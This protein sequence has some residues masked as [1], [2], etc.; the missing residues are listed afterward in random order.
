MFILPGLG[1]DSTATPS[2][3]PTPAPVRPSLSESRL[4]EL[5]LFTLQL[6][7]KDRID[8]GLSPVALGSNPAAQSH[9]E[10]MLVH[11]YLGHWWVDGRKPYMVYSETRGQSYV[12]ENAASSGWTQEGWENANCDS[13][14]VSCI[15]TQPADALKE[16]EHL[17]MYDDAHADWGHRDNILGN[18]HRFVNIGIAWDGRRT[19]LAQHFEG[20]DV[21]ANGRPALSTDGTLSFRLTKVAEDIEVGDLVTVYYDPPPSPKTPAQIDTLDSYCIGGGFTTACDHKPVAR[22]LE[23]PGPGFYY[24][25]LDPNEIV[26]DSWSQSSTSFEVTA[27]LGSRATRPGVYTVMVWQ[28]SGSPL[29]SDFWVA[30]SVVQP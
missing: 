23:P 30:L 5:R 13:V 3:T 27:S 24:P 25:N 9:A 7:N 17:M 4:A 15:I 29:F 11:G 22:I 1:V 8:H 21:V 2:A 6:I 18:T 14:S 12:S 10:D 20:G 28:D 26:A 16:A 19:V